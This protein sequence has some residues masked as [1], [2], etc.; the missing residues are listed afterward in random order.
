MVLEEIKSGTLLVLG[1]MKYHEVLNFILN[2]CYLMV[3]PQG[4]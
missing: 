1:T 3:P 4:P 2:F